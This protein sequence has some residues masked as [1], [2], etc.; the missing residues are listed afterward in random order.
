ME[1]KRGNKNDVWGKIGVK[2]RFSPK[3]CLSVARE[4]IFKS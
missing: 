4:A 2:Y 3:T 1:E